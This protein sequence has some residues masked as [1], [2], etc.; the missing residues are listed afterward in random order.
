MSVAK[1]CSL[2]DAF[3][4]YPG[5]GG[6]TPV[7]PFFP[8]LWDLMVLWEPHSVMEPQRVMGASQGHGASR[9]HGRLTMPARSILEGKPYMIWLFPSD[10]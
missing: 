8:S 3:R 1:E 9:C 4:Q 6:V 10:G 7:F 5:E 2:P